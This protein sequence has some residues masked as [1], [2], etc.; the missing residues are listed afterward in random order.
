MV[1]IRDAGGGK[2]QKAYLAGSFQK[3]SETILA[4]LEQGG[5]GLKENKKRIPYLSWRWTEIRHTARA[6]QSEGEGPPGLETK[7]SKTSWLGGS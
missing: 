7:G 1:Q 6:A 3:T 2:R 4:G 5:G